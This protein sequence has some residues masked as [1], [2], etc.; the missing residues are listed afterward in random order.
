MALLQNELWYVYHTLHSRMLRAVCFYDMYVIISASFR[1]MFL[2][3][4]IIQ[5]IPAL[6]CILCG[7]TMYLVLHTAQH[8]L[9]LCQIRRV[10]TLLVM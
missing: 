9:V 4:T 1:H 3:C 7:K 6:Y 10:I 8:C 2:V 5:H